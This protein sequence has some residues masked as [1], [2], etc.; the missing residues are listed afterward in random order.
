M[1]PHRRAPGG[2]GPFRGSVVERGSSSDGDDPSSAL[3][4][5]ASKLE[6]IVAEASDLIR[7]TGHFYDRYS[8][9]HKNVGGEKIG[10]DKASE[11]VPGGNSGLLGN[12]ATAGRYQ[13]RGAAT[14]AGQSDRCEGGH[15]AASAGAA[16]ERSFGANGCSAGDPP[17]GV[18]SPKQL[19]TRGHQPW[20]GREDSGN[21]LD[22]TLEYRHGVGTGPALRELDRAC[23]S[24]LESNAHLCLRLQGLGLEYAGLIRQRMASGA[25]GPLDGEHRHGCGF[26]PQQEP[27]DVADLLQDGASVVAPV[28]CHHRGRSTGYRAER[29]HD[30]RSEE[31]HSAAA[32]APAAA[33]AGTARRDDESRR[34]RLLHRRAGESPPFPPRDAP[35]AKGEGRRERC[36]AIASA[37][38]AAAARGGVKEPGRRR[39]NRSADHSPDGTDVRRFCASSRR[40]A[41]RGMNSSH[42]AHHHHHR[43]SGGL[44]REPSVERRRVRHSED[45]SY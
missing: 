6:R 36:D 23:Y 34:H 5:Q 12:D 37:A 19:P 41:A 20:R 16:I 42:H 1:S 27:L 25:G 35:I 28:E 45:R 40:S 15:R 13:N 33:P 30:G 9:T 26:R 43:R 14:G 31:R 18:F 29:R 39:A 4:L 7:Q 2:I 10:D 24:L 17:P 22:R 32:A 8:E 21:F 44:S 38:A 3:G 11:K